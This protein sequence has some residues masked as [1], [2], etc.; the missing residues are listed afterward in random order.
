MPAHMAKRQM[1]PTWRRHTIRLALVG[2]LSKRSRPRMFFPHEGIFVPSR[3]AFSGEHRAMRADIGFLIRLCDDVTQRWYAASRQS[4]EISLRAHEHLRRSERLLR[5]QERFHTD[6][7][8]GSRPSSVSLVELTPPEC[9][10]RRFQ[11]MNASGHWPDPSHPPAHRS[12]PA[13]YRR[14]IPLPGDRSR[15]RSISCRL[16]SEQCGVQTF[17]PPYRDR[18]QRSYVCSV[19]PIFLAATATVAP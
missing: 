14:R 15:R 12:L 9:R 18:R 8:R 5:Q 13:W 4:T 17:H 1:H 16:I 3:T 19:T 10:Q 2:R 11:P 7:W 6:V